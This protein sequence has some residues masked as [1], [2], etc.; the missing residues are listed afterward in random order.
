MTETHKPKRKETRDH[1]I[2]RTIAEIFKPQSDPHFLALTGVELG[3]FWAVHDAGPG[4][5]GG[6]EIRLV[7]IPQPGDQ[8]YQAIRMVGILKEENA[9]VDAR[10]LIELHAPAAGWDAVKFEELRA[11][12]DRD[13]HAGWYSPVYPDGAPIHDKTPGVPTV[14]LRTRRRL[15]GQDNW[16]RRGILFVAREGLSAA[17]R[18]PHHNNLIATV[19]A[20]PRGGH[21]LVP[22]EPGDQIIVNQAHLARW[23]IMPDGTILGW[24]PAPEI[25]GLYEEAPEDF[26]PYSPETLL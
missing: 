6:L 22:V 2:S 13:L 21:R 25:L 18:L 12:M 5:A 20:I 14:V 17:S 11:V 24:A 26:D 15:L 19:I 1:L 16:E 9:T 4:W 7:F 8:Q 23:M 10:G 3:P